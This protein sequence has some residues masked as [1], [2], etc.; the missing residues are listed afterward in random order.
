MRYF[1]VF[2]HSLF[3]ENKAQIEFQQVW[4]LLFFFFTYFSSLMKTETVS[5]PPLQAAEIEEVAYVKKI[6]VTKG[7]RIYIVLIMVE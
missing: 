1:T 2:L 6:I 3:L 4:F 5:S 7:T